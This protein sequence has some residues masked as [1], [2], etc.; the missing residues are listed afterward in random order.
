M[1]ENVARIFGRDSAVAVA[2]GGVKNK[3]KLFCSSVA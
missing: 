3:T 1:R 2:K